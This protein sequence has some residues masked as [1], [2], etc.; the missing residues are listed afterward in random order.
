MILESVDN[1][2]SYPHS[3]HIFLRV[4]HILLIVFRSTRMLQYLYIK[5][6]ADL[7][8]NHSTRCAFLETRLKL[9]DISVKKFNLM[10]LNM[11]G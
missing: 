5:Q 8:V 6:N 10:K 2:L 3:I 9:Q 7:I 1:I 4:I 11:G